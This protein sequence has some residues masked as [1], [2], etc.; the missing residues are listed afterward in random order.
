M[1][2]SERIYLKKGQRIEL[3]QYQDGRNREVYRILS[4]VG[5]GGSAVCYE[6]VREL[7][8]QTGKLK[9]FY[10]VDAVNGAQKWY[11]SLDRLSNGQLVPNGGT[12]RKFDELCRE[13]LKTYQLLIGII[14]DDPQNEILKNFIQ[15]GDIRYGCIE[16]SIENE[17][18][19]T[20]VKRKLGGVSADVHERATVYIWSTGIDGQR[21]DEHLNELKQQPDKDSDHKLYEILQ[22]MSSLTDFIKA[23]HTVGLMHLDIKPANFLVPY[24]S[25]YSV[26]P[27]SISMFDINTLYSVDSDEPRAVGTDGYR[28]PEIMRG[29]ADNRSDIYSLGAML[30]NAIVISDDVSD[31]LYRD[32]YYSEIDQLVRHSKLITGAESNSDVRLMSKL[33][34]ILKKC[35]ARNPADRY[36]SCSRLLKDLQ[37]AENRLT[38]FITPVGQNRRLQIV[39]VNEKGISD[40]VTV[41]QKLLHDHPLYEV[42]GPGKTDINVLVVGSGT[43]GQKFI[44]QCLQAGQMKG[45][46]L[47]IHAV[48]DTPDEDLES[49]LQFRPAIRR[50]VDINGSMKNDRERSYGTLVFESLKQA[51]GDTADEA[52]LRFRTVKT[53]SAEAAEK[54]NK[55]IIS[56][57]IS[58]ALE[59]EAVYDYIF[60][61]LGD[62]RTNYSI[63]KCFSDTLIGWDAAIICPVCFISANGRKSTKKEQADMLCSVCINETITPETI[64][65]DLDQ[66]AF[67]SDI[68]WNSTLNIDVTETYSKFVL[69]RYRYS[70][71]LSYALS[72]KYKLYSIGIVQDTEAK[73]LLEDADQFIVVKD[74]NE[75]AKVFSERI[76]A[77]K[78]MDVDAKEKFATIVALEH[79]RW[80]LEKVTDGWTAPVD[81]GGNLDLESCVLNGMVKNPARR[82]HPCI[83]FSTEESPLSGQDYSVDGHKKWDDPNIDQNLDELD[84]MSVELH[85]C[86]RAKADEFKKDNPL[87]SEDMEAIWRL[88]SGADEE[89]IRAYRQFQFCLKN[90]LNGVESYTRQYDYYEKFF[91]DSLDHLSEDIKGKIE[92]RMPLIKKAFFPVIEADLF[93]NYKANDEIPVE[94]IPFILTYHFQPSI[95]MAFEDGRYQNGRN[96]AVF[97][98]VAAATVLSPEKIYYFYYYDLDSKTDQLSH[99]ITAVLNYLSKRKVHCAVSFAAACSSLV[100][101]KK[102]EGLQKSLEHLVKSSGAGSG[103]AVLE[104]YEIFDCPDVRSAVS[105]LLEYRSKVHI[106]LYDGSTQLFHSVMDDG[107]FAEKIVKE[108]TPY[109]EFDWKRKIFTKHEHCDYLKYICDNSCIRINDMFSLMNA[110][111]NKFNLPEFADDYEALWG[112]YTGSYL[113]S[114]KFENGVGNWNRLCAILAAYEEKRKPLASISMVDDKTAVK[115]EMV[116]LLPEFVYRQAAYI[117]SKL[118]EYGVADPGSKL[119][120]YTS[121]DCRLNVIAAPEYEGALNSVFSNTQSM[122]YGVDVV[123]R[124]DYNGETVLVTCNDPAVVNL[125]LDPGGK[126]RQKYSCSILEKLREGHFISQLTQNAEDN[127]LVSFTYSSGR[128]KKLMTS[129]GEILEVYSYYQVLKSGYFDDAAC[130]YEFRWETDGVKNELDLVLTKGFRSIIVECKA[131]QKLDLEYYHKLHSIAEHFGIGTIKVLIGNTYRHNDV[132]INAVNKM[133]RS[134]G[135]QLNIITISSQSK[136]EN[137]GETLKELME[138]E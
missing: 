18:L 116:F 115:K 14:A 123:K 64:S 5:E 28:A 39:N 25:D 108:G 94:K 134:R 56:G 15:I 91:L 10:P 8:G 16:S 50:F 40:P 85:Q 76:L 88:I 77:R 89:T 104:N 114:N 53:G 132:N 136:I 44:D 51:A 113:S 62:D 105:E 71:S 137:I 42:T 119:I 37:D 103:N 124:T 2:G 100:D 60:I 78:G 84:R 48:S 110:V 86:F 9:E 11:Y 133:Q 101:S 69:D 72:I 1:E 46:S 112:I 43:Y 36:E 111:D 4:V 118:K 128:I 35:L 65:P 61:A 107:L 98:N 33:A 6:A 129:A 13:Y 47:H 7:D 52:G 90:I 92:A 95:A 81:E 138:E 70:S 29:R 45:Y 80:V 55:A 24:K 67:N 109:F 117:L 41:I 23:L 75:A 3:A 125:D 32:L 68:S 66:M 74:A 97:T 57:I 63:A 131:V 93:R 12:V 59:N 26:N 122:L 96:E 73:A 34:N 21:Y 22:T 19:I 17:G 126:G 102:R 130:G 135:N 127:R 99:K 87:Q 83:V 30:F 82:T 31:G 121:E 49:Y 120:S 106:D 27:G 38:Q 54:E 20:R 58:S 79:R